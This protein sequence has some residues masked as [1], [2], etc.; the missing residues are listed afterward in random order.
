M[1]TVWQTIERAPEAAAALSWRRWLG[2]AFDA[3]AAVCLHATTRTVDCIPC[4]NGCARSHA[5]R[6]RGAALVGICGYGEDC[7]DVPLTVADITV[8]EVDL[9]RL[10][11]ALAKA[12]GCGLTLAP[13]G[14]HRTIQV[15]ALGNPVVPVVLTVQPDAENYRNAVAYLLAHLPKGFILLTPTKLGDANTLE[16]LTK[17]SVGFYDLES[18]L[19]LL[20]SGKLHSAKTADVLFAAHLPAT[21]E[22]VRDAESARV[23][24]L[25]SELLGMGAKLKASPAQVFDLMVFKKKT[26]AE[27]AVACKCARSLITKRVAVIENHF[28]MTIEKLCDFASDLKDRLTTVK[29]D[30]YAKKKHGS[31]QVDPKE[32]DDDNNDDSDSNRE[33]YVY[34]NEGKDD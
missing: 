2:P 11:R 28:D 25:F 1:A 34:E 5:V 3:V 8:W 17:A 26:H 16:L 14:F 9:S 7:D 22:M 24:R 29:G 33:E 6:K 31:P 10:A 32:P 30:R 21:K 23:W 15:A 4:E 27:T 19:T 20:P 18:H 13:V 12:L